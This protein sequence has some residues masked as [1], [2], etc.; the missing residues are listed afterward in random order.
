MPATKAIHIVDDDV[1]F[2]RAI[3]RLIKAHGL[4]V[5]AFS[6]VEEF[7]VKAN[8]DDAACL[9]L[10]VHLGNVSGIDLM[11]D[12][13][14]SGMKT[15]VLLVTG[16]DSDNVRRAAVEAG[17]DVCLQKPVSAKALMDALRKVTGGAIVPL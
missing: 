3:E 7:Q 11:R 2:L 8:P 1:G 15:P 6:S 9:I 16:R 4:E 5:R 10:D 12:L 14:N 17:C 13:V